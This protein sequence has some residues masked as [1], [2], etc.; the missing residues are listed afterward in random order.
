MEEADRFLVL[1]HVCIL[2]RTEGHIAA[3]LHM[4]VRHCV[5][6]SDELLEQC[7]VP[8]PDCP[9]H[10]LAA[11]IRVSTEE[12][13]RL[14]LLPCPHLL[15][16]LDVCPRRQTTSSLPGSQ[17]LVRLGLLRSWRTAVLGARSCLLRS[18]RRRRAPSKDAHELRIPFRDTFAVGQVVDAGVGIILIRELML[19]RF[20]DLRSCRLGN[21]D[22]TVHILM[23]LDC[24]GADERPDWDGVD[25]LS[26]MEHAVL[27]FVQPFHR[28]FCLFVLVSKQDVILENDEPVLAVA[29]RVHRQYLSCAIPNVPFRLSVQCLAARDL[30][31]LSFASRS[32]TVRAHSCRCWRVCRLRDGSLNNHLLPRF[33]RSSRRTTLTVVRAHSWR[34]W[35]WGLNNLLLPSF[36]RPSRPVLGSRRHSTFRF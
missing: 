27:V 9:N 25:F 19:Q 5:C 22:R 7:G 14:P 17:N 35:R 6:V 2:G 31:V 3:L 34:C 32:L 18:T 1:H 28:H 8:T 4:Q 24:H 13:H 16:N 33:G 10:L 20:L 12:I 15:L 21:L 23:G 29:C 36:D 11:P 30:F 26:R